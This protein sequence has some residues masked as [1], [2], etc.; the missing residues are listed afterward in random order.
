MPRKIF[1]QE[2]VIELGTTAKTEEF[3]LKG[4]GHDNGAGGRYAEVV[5]KLYLGNVGGRYFVTPQGRID[6]RKFGK[7]LTIKTGYGCVWH[8][9]RNGKPTSNEFIGSDFLIWLGDPLSFPGDALVVPTEDFLNSDLLREVYGSC[10]YVGDEN[11]APKG[12]LVEGAYLNQ[13]SFITNKAKV[14]LAML[15]MSVGTLDQFLDNKGNL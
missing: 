5:V 14:D 12:T 15:E 4:K 8:N 1:Y 10:M 6:T 3:R 7:W 9:D 11:I 2:K 13:T